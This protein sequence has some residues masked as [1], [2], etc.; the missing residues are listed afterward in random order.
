MLA[1]QRDDE[2]VQPGGLGEAAVAGAGLERQEGRGRA[3]ARLADQVLGAQATHQGGVD[4][5]AL[6]GELVEFLG[7][8][9]HVLADHVG[10]QHSAVEALEA[11][12]QQLPP[13][14]LR[15]EVLQLPEARHAQAVPGGSTRPVFE[16]AW[17]RI[18]VRIGSVSA[19]I[20]SRSTWSRTSVRK[21][22]NQR[23]DVNVAD[24]GEDAAVLGL[25]ALQ[26]AGDTIGE[27]IGGPLDRVGRVARGVEA[28]LYRGR[29]IWRRVAHVSWRSSASCGRREKSVSSGRRLRTRR[30][31]WSSARSA[32]RASCGC[33]ASRVRTAALVRGARLRVRL[34]LLLLGFLLP[35]DVLLLLLQPCAVLS[36]L[37]PSF[38][39]VPS[40]LPSRRSF[41][42]CC[43]S[44]SCRSCA[45]WRA[46]C[47]SS[48]S[49]SL[50]LGV[51]TGASVFVPPPQALIAAAT[52][53]L[54][55]T[56][57]ARLERICSNS[58]D[59]ERTLYK[60]LE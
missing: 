21:S 27:P 53:T 34:R 60:L 3:V 8:K 55:G 45:R 24:G 33:C 42:S 37:V 12:G 30:R 29:A 23:F 26:L 35:A 56:R 11:E 40:V 43:S 7:G 13:G 17:A 16:N 44:R 49:A 41:A 39:A 19:R 59:T 50:T 51:V 22:A 32:R 36:L 25:A 58:G 20:R 4:R 15:P 14:R 28:Q 46:S 2:D 9:G 38:P 5:E 1:A 31:S 57:K 54:S 48:R 47:L 52:A 6:L 18:I 10:D